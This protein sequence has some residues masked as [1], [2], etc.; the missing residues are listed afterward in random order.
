[1]ATKL[2]RF[3]IEVTIAEVDKQFHIQLDGR[4]LKTLARQPLAL[5]GRPLAELVAQEWRN[6]T[7][8][9]D[10]DSMPHTRLANIALDR[11]PTERAAIT[12]TI[13]M[14]AETDLLCHRAPEEALAA[15]Q[16]QH[17][18]PVLA[19]L[20]STYGVRMRLTTGV[21]PMPQ[22]EESLARLSEVIAGAGN[23]AFAGIAMLT[24][25]LGSVLLAVALWKKGV[26]LDAAVRACHLDQEYQQQ[27]WGK[28]TEDDVLWHRKVLEM[29]ACVQWLA[30]CE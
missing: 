30:H 2:T 11:V 7:A 16:T 26:A 3:Y 29:G 23:F 25:L 17:W 24:P 12:Q 19:W 8:Q 9:I 28:V 15:L 10:P 27:Q 1:M 4:T 13:L 5:P 18:D 22:P 14:F 21:L 6:Q 20:E